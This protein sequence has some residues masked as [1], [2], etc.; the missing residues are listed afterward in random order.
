[1]AVVL[2]QRLLR[3]GD[4]SA[5][6][7]DSF[8][9]E[10]WSRYRSVFDEVAVVARAETAAEPDPYMRR[11]D[12]DGVSLVPVPM[13]V[14]PS[15]L[16]RR[17]NSVRKAIAGAVNEADA[18]VL[19]APGT[20]SNLAFPVVE[21]FGRPLGVEVLGDPLEVFASNVT[22]HPLRPLLRRWF[23][24]S[25]R[26]QCQAADVV[27][28][29]TEHTL[30]DRYPPGRSSFSTWYSTVE[31]PEEAYAPMPPAVRTQPPFRTV[32]VASLDH[33]YKGVDSALA[34]VAWCPPVPAFRLD[35]I[36]DGRYRRALEAR[37]ADLGVD[38]RVTF[39]GRLPGPEA[40]RE[41]LRDADLFL[42]A[43]RTE[44]LPRALLEAMALGLPCLATAVGGIPEL[45]D[46]DSLVPPDASDQLGA[47]VLDVLAEPQRR[48]RMSARNHLVARSYR[49]EILAERRLAAY[50]QLARLAAAASV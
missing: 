23:A 40:V 5:W 27:C 31:L 39:M 28:Y 47:R 18:V 44:G 10:F 24:G 36:G 34:A 37:A 19:R 8:P 3:A 29:V 49:A 2:E 25:L 9:R 35:V 12:G 46:E 11:V 4:G 6:T 21:R 33:M 7:R 22:R 26:R 14:G 42:L 20:L 32:T 41:Q 48:S 13:Y 43:S 45:L 38:D 17:I 30:Q 1:M 16:A 50:G 15:A